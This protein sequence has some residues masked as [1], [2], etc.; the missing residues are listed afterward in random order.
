MQI[1]VTGSLAFDQIMNF[2]ESFSD[3]IMPDKLHV[4]SASFMVDAMHKNFGGVAGNIS[5]NLGILR[6]NPICLSSIGQD[7]KDYVALLKE[8]GVNTDYI[9]LSKTDYTG[10]FVVITDQNDCQ[11][12]GFYPGAMKND[13]NLSL[14]DVVKEGQDYFLVVA[15]TMPEAMDNFVQEAVELKIPFM[16]SP[17]QQLPKL[18]KDQILFGVKHADI[19][20]GSDY[21]IALL[22]KRADL[23]HQ[24][25]IEATNIVVTT[26]GKAGSLIEQQGKPEIKI[27]VAK[28]RDIKDPTGAGDGY[29]AGFLAAY[30]NGKSLVECGQ[31]AATGA[32]Y[33]VENYGTTAHDF[34]YELFQQRLK[35]NFS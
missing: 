33:P 22:E 5:Y 29:I 11:I 26:L 27:G 14:K 1:I 12:A 17:S 21:E 3:Y 35:E 4:I 20:I 6:E 25:L 23:T 9:N 2:P 15:P 30:L 32:V 8:S 10:S 18:T 7:G 34:T 31:W 16:Y 28:P 13:T 24:Q 19:V